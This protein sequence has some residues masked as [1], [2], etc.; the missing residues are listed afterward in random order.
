MIVSFGQLSCSQE[1]GRRERRLLTW[2]HVSIMDQGSWTVPALA[3]R[4]GRNGA[5]LISGRGGR[6]E[7][8][9]FWQQFW[10]GFWLVTHTDVAAVA[11]LSLL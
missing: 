1:S 8:E 10:S 5:G 9:D 2:T 6:R 11:A 3:Q 7:R 4:A